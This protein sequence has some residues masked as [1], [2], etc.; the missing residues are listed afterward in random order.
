VSVHNLVD[1]SEKREE[2][3]LPLFDEVEGGD[4]AV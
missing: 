4:G 2:I 1:P 3:R